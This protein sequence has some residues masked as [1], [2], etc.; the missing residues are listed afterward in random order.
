MEKKRA[1]R[2]YHEEKQMR[3]QL[4]SLTCKKQQE[5]KKCTRYKAHKIQKVTRFTIRLV[6][7]FSNLIYDERR[8]ECVNPEEKREDTINSMNKSHKK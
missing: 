2:V 1:E 5:N 4:G 7:M 8:R 6:L 3:S